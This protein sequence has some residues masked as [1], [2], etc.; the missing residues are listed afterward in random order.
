MVALAHGRASDYLEGDEEIGMGSAIK[1]VKRKDRREAVSPS[2]GTG[3]RSGKSEIVQTVKNW[4]SE[5][6]N[7]RHAEAE[8]A[9]QFMRGPEFRQS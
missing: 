5:S 2:M 6:R 3:E 1:I 4:I 7:R 8:L 9:L